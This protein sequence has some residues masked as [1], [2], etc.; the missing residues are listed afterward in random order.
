M[1]VGRLAGHDLDAASARRW[2]SIPARRRGT[3]NQRSRVGVSAEGNGIVA[4]GEG[5]NGSTRA[6]SPGSTRRASR[7]SSRC[8]ASAASPGG[9]G[10]LARHRHRGRR[11]VRVGDVPPGHRRRVARDRAPDAR[12]DLRPAG[13]A[14]RR[15]GLDRAAG[16]DQRPR[17]G[18]RDVRDAGRRRG[19][20]S[21]LPR[22]LRAGPAAALGGVDAGARSPSRPPPSTARTWSPGGSPTAA[23]TRRSRAACSRSR[24]SRSTPRSTLSRPDLGAGAGRPVRGGRRPPRGLRRRDGPGAAGGAARSPSRCTTALPGRPGAIARSAWQSAR[25]AKLEWRPGP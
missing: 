19:A 25:R 13:A 2:T 4:W 23:A 1:R 18:A 10:R 24:R 22:R 6:A 21:A 16:G 3:G 14:R 20:A 17:P 8:P 11:L 9:R 12:L 7:R 5:D 15:P